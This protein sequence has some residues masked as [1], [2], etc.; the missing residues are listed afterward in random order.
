VPPS[1]GEKTPN[2][3]APPLAAPLF[4][5]TGAPGRVA[6]LGRRLAGCVLD[7]VLPSAAAV[8]VYTVCT[9]VT[10]ERSTLEMSASLASVMMVQWWLIGWRGQSVGKIIMRTRIACADGSTP[11]VVRGVMVRAWPIFAV[12]SLPSLLGPTPWLRRI[13]VLAWLLDAVFIF[14][15]DR[16]CAH[17][18]MAGTF[19]V[20]VSA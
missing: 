17:D 3:Y 10:H 18:H 20:D 15:R 4:A 13:V 19:V 2:P 9:K 11:G 5:Q 12:S 1:D 7:L 16:R 8:L 6:S 14:L